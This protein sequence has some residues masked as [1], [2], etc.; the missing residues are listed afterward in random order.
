MSA[1]LERKPEVFE[2]AN[3]YDTRRL[4]NAAKRWTWFGL[5]VILPERKAELPWLQVGGEETSCPC[6]QKYG[7]GFQP[8]GFAAMLEMGGEPIPMQHMGELR[9]TAWQGG[10]PNDKQ[11]M[12]YVPVYPGDGLRLLKRY[13]TNDGPGGKGLDELETLQGLEWEECHD[14][15]G[16]GILDVIE[17]AQFGDGMA[18]TLKGL[19]EQI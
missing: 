13:A 10:I 7:R 16:G 2:S 5:D 14:G 6:L 12:G 11:S 3:Y 9:A 18:K 15:N 19:E 8:K 1:V 4:T 17:L